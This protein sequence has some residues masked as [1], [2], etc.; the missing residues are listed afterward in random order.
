MESVEFND[1]NYFDENDLH[2]INCIKIYMKSIY[3]SYYDF[4]YCNQYG[5]KFIDVKHKYKNNLKIYDIKL[6]RYSIIPKM[7]LEL[8]YITI[9]NM[10]GIEKKIYPNDKIGKYHKSKIVD[11]K[12]YLK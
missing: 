5:N 1:E 12:I 2:I 9:Q 6:I 7:N 10:G 4:T 3:I 11:V 8:D